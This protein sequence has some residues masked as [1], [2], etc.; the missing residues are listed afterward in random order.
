MGRLRQAQHRP[1]P[2][3]ET[4]KQQVC[5][6]PHGEAPSPRVSLSRACLL[7][8]GMLPALTQQEMGTS[9]LEKACLEL[10][11]SPPPHRRLTPAGGLE[12]AGA[13]SPEP[14][15]APRCILWARRPTS[16][17]FK[18]LAYLSLSQ[19]RAPRVRGQG[20][21]QIEPPVKVSCHTVSCWEGQQAQSAPGRAPTWV[22]AGHGGCLEEEAVLL[23]LWTD[24]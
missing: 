6:H 23:K 14:E 18:S 8:K 21:I 17:G 16:L 19:R 15:L 7:T 12:Q 3:A 9:P 5:A 10:R 20:R 13:L 4:A 24:S 1:R 22:W 2:K 11:P